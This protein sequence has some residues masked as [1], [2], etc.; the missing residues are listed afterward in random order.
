SR[1]TSPTARGRGHHGRG[2]RDPARD[3]SRP[4]QGENRDPGDEGE[5]GTRRPGDAAA[6][7]ATD[8]S[9][10]RALMSIVTIDQSTG[11]LVIDGSKVFPIGL[12]DGPPLGGKTRDGKDAWA[13][14]ASAGANFI[15]SGFRDWN[16][17]QIDGQL[18]AERARMD[19]ARGH[20]LHCWP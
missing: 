20:G 7:V 14:V 6:T 19:A 11:C 4:A 16:L 9:R 12:S 2:A 15:R 3:P 1:A 18:A 17:Q 8:P 5:R 13:E 10:V